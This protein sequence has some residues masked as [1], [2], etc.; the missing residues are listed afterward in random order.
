ML[1]SGTAFKEV[2]VLGYARAEV[3]GPAHLVD[4]YSF[5]LAAAQTLAV[6]NT[7]TDQLGLE[8]GSEAITTYAQNVD[9]SFSKNPTTASWDRVTNTTGF[10]TGSSAP[11]TTPP[12]VP[13]TLPTTGVASAGAASLTYYVRFT[14]ANGTELTL[15][16]DQLFQLS[17]FA[18]DDKQT[19]NIGSAT[20]G[21]GAGKVTFNPLTLSFTQQGLAPQLLQMLASGTAF[22]EVD[23]LGYADGVGSTPAHLVDAYSFGLAAAQTLAVDNTGTD[24]LGLEY[25]SEAIQTYAQ[26]VDGSFSKD[27]TTAS[28]DRVTNTTGFSTGSSAPTTTPPTVP[29]TLPTTG[30]ASAGAASLTYYVRFTLANGTELTLNNDQLF[31]LSSFAFDDKQTL[32]IGSATSG[33]GAGKVTFDPLTLSFTQQGLA[34]QLLQMLAS[35]TAFKEVDVLGYARA[36]VGGPAHLV[37][38]YSFGLAAAQTLAVDNTG[39][40]QLG[41]E[42]GSEAITTYAQNVD[43]SFPKNPTTA[44]WD[45]VTNTTGFSTGSSAPTTTPPTVPITLPTTG[46]AS[47]GAASLTYYVRFTLAN[48]TELT[49][50]NDQLFQLSSFA[51]DDKQTLN[52]GSAT[53]GAGAGKVTFNPLTLSFTQQGLAPQ[54]L[55]ILASGTAF[56][57]VDVLGYARAVGSTPGPLGRRLQ[58]RPHR[59][60][61]FG[62]GQYRHGPAR[63]R[64]RQRGHHDLRPERRRELPHEP[65]DDGV[66]GPRH[67]YDRLFDGIERADDHAA[68]GA[69]HLADHGCGVGRRGLAHLLRS[70]HAGERDRADPEQRPAVPAQQLRLRRRADAEHRQRDE[71]RGGGQGHLRPADPVVHAAG[72]RPA[73]A[74]DAGV[75]HGLQ[76]G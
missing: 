60:P 66:V 15:N 12:T 14:L 43:G 50:N 28:W 61:D 58:L 4:A 26:N 53:S 40:D 62:G 19:L 65:D 47:A 39:T 34:P 56:K 42:Y 59:R 49:L 8:Y 33:A 54:L 35:G 25:G 76:G 3:G 13:I 18:F 38:A 63:P 22:K 72:P 11:T 9:G 21:A 23:V 45:R 2:D 52:I 7:G 55:Q 75:G 20:S 70:V 51:F 27:P 16:N 48:G 71:R 69:D 73:A 36:E 74:A 41:L 64:I 6:D 10:S 1:A 24:Q 44:S 32:N 37:D 57:E 30:V 17:S 67:Q 5:G 29:T 68:D 46:V 31:Q